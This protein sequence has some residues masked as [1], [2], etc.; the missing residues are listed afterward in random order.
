MGGLHVQNGYIRLNY[1]EHR[2]GILYKH[3]GRNSLLIC[4]V[5]EA[6]TQSMTWHI[7]IALM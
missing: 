5:P 6:V 7:Y 2:Q 4:S 1:K 3:G